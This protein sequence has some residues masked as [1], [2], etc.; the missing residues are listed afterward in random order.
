VYPGNVST[1]AEPIEVRAAS[2]RRLDLRSL[3]D[4]PEG[5]DATWTGLGEPPVELHWPVAGIDAVMRVSAPTLCIVAAS[6]AGL[7]AV[8]VEPQ[9]HA[10]Q[11]LRRLLN[12]EPDAL[13]LLSPG[14]T[15]AISIELAFALSSR[16][17]GRGTSEMGE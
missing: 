12:G 17:S 1:E 13:A 6:F 15:L 3:Q 4:M 10:P 16:R 7:D 9:T 11:G 5:V 8:G 2:D 14:E